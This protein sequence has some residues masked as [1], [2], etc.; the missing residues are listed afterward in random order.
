M[1]IILK[2]ESKT[3]KLVNK[4]LENLLRKLDDSTSIFKSIT[5]DNGLEFASLTKLERQY[6]GDIY[7]IA[8]LIT[9]KKE[10]VMKNIMV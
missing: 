7:I 3:S 4:S 9:H 6:V 10:V 8:I 2:I 1:E 5:S